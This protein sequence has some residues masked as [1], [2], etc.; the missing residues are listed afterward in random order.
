[1]EAALEVRLNTLAWAQGAE[2][3]AEEQMA[4]YDALPQVHAVAL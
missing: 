1:M 4:V 2:E 3:A